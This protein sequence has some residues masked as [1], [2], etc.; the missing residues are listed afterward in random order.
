MAL[1][2]IDA[3]GDQPFAQGKTMPVA[4]ELERGLA[5]SGAFPSPRGSG[6]SPSPRPAPVIIMV[7]GYRF[8]PGDPVH[9]PHSHI[10]SDHDA[11]PCRK[12]VSWPRGL[13]IGADRLGLAFGWPARGSIW[14]AHRQA[15]AAGRALA[16]VITL[17]RQIDPQREIHAIGHSL[18]ARVLLSA[19]SA[20]GAPA[21]GQ[22]LLLAGA[23][24]VSHLEAARASP[25]GRSARLLHV[26]SRENLLYDLLLAGLV[27]GKGAGDRVLGRAVHPALPQLRLDDP[28]HLAGLAAMG[29]ALGRPERRICHWSSYLRPGA[30]PLYHALTGPRG[31]ALHAE[32]TRIAAKRPAPVRGGL[33]LPLPWGANASS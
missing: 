13:G 15:D 17:I 12:A 5:R 1:I 4:A 14:Q 26:T 3:I 2:R 20:L 30:F 10:L 27:G 29:F 19:L 6:P 22:V 28:Q 7:H 9:C 25:A 11:H 31:A 16:Q 32:V 24:H 33:S 8:Q 18:G 23:D 21:L